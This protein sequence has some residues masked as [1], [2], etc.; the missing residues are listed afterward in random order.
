MEKINYPDIIKRARNVVEKNKYDSPEISLYEIRDLDVFEDDSIS[1]LCWSFMN[2]TAGAPT[3]DEVVWL[4]DI[5]EDK[6]ISLGLV[7]K[8]D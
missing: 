7:E 1:N 3:Y 5:A 8:N 4:I 6:L 2:Y